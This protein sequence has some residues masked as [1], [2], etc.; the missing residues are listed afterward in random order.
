MTRRPWPILPWVRAAVLTLAGLLLLTPVL[1]PLAGLRL[2][3]LKGGSMAPTYQPGDVVLIGEPTGA[4]FDLGEPVLIGDPPTAYLHRVIETDGTRAKLRGDAN[5]TPDPGR[6]TQD[7]VTGI[8]VGH[9][10]QPAAGMIDAATGLPGRIVLAG[11][12]LAL[13]IKPFRTRRT[14]S[15][16]GSSPS[17]SPSDT[18][19]IARSTAQH[20]VQQEAQHE[21]Q[22]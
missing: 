21:G 17:P 20:E 14:A 5:A 11:A 13:L 6:V 12:V 16:P 3:V 18:D 15:E 9:L 4:D 7:D 19:G 22:L 2:I 8:V 1:L 10:G